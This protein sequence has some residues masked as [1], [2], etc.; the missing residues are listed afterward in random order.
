MT[1]HNIIIPRNH[2]HHI[3]SFVV[4]L[5]LNKDNGPPPIQPLSLS[6]G[7]LKLTSNL[8][9]CLDLEQIL[10]KW[11]VQTKEKNGQPGQSYNDHYEWMCRYFHRFL[12]FSKVKESR[13][14]KA[15]H[16]CSPINADNIRKQ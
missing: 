12:R 6:S 4:V 11:D 5:E 16:F 7:T 8:F 3:F 9:F 13:I 10:S 14:L 2:C 15:D 1:L